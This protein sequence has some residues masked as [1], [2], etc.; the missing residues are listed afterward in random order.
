MTN[1]LNPTAD[2][3]VPRIRE[4]LDIAKVIT[5]HIAQSVYESSPDEARD[6]RSVYEPSPDEARDALSTNPLVRQQS[7]QRIVP[8]GS[9]MKPEDLR[10][11]AEFGRAIA[12]LADRAAERSASVTIES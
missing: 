5:R 9:R 6:D 1:Y 3:S 8:P 10:I 12:V 7:T 11:V 2:D 4:I